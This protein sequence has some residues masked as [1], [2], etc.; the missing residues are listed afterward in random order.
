[1]KIKKIWEYAFIAVC[2]TV[3]SF[4]L[5][6]SIK[7]ES[8]TYDEVTYAEYGYHF[9]VNHDFRYDPFSPPLAKE[10]V[11]LPA[12]INKNVIYDRIIFWPRMVTVVFTLGLAGLIY[13][14]SKKLFGETSAKFSLLLVVF[15]PNLLA[16]GHYA[17]ADLIFTF[18]Y[19]LSLFFFW[20]WRK[21][22]T[23]KRIIIFS[24]ITGLL[25]S[26]KITSIPFFIF[27]VIVLYALD[28]KRKRDLI[29]YAFWKK[30]IWVFL[31]VV[32]IVLVTLWATYF[33]K[34]EPPL[35]Y[36]FDQNRPAIALSKTNPLIKFALTVPIP[37][38]SYL[39][40]IKQTFLY[41]YSNLYI[42]RSYILGMASLYGSPGYY[43]P[44]VFF[45]KTPLPLLM[46]LSLCL[47]IPFKYVK[48]EKYI[49]IP[50]LFIFLN[51]I[52]S[53]VTLVNRYILPVYPLV[54][55]YAGQLVN[56]KTVRK[57]I[58]FLFLGVLLIWYIAG[59]L[60]T[61]PYFV[62]YMNEAIGGAGNRYKFLVD[63]NYDWG[64]GLIA[65]KK[66]EDNQGIRSLQL[67]YFGSI[68]P[69][70]YG[71]RYE[72]IKNLAIN[73][74]K[75]TVALKFDKN[76]TIAISATCWYFCG[77]DKDPAFS[78]RSPVAVVGGSILIFKKY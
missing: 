13:M 29:K 35:G 42:K 44:L 39:S 2:L 16:N 19:I 63:S 53:H 11:A 26:T 72:K 34:F 40:T 56:I 23:R 66:Y 10:I 41:N 65:L 31:A 1:M 75:R 54:I 18:F 49:L 33:F 37:L 30:R 22:F 69:A 38:G 77:Y 4:L 9:L 21:K 46:L 27:P 58:L 24:I 67:A 12:L 74:N 8:P 25:L 50:L 5:I 48:K 76:H 57:T 28:V 36:R 55:I 68:D 43:F 52:L 51:V 59:T 17:D 61:F 47:L 14:F 64:Q 6:G 60:K 78:K 7:Q 62:S 73:D 15:E 20:L 71:I 70:K 45:I 32:F 3:M